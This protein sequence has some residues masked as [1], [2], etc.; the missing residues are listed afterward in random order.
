M[1]TLVS[2]PRKPAGA[3]EE[4]AEKLGEGGTG[5]KRHA[6]GEPE[7]MDFAGEAV[8]IVGRWSGETTE[9]TGCVAVA[10]DSSSAAL[11]KPAEGG[12]N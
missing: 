8:G 1:T 2:R 9:E 11:E 3:V 12:D 5:A 7:K 10:E 6:G 4:Q